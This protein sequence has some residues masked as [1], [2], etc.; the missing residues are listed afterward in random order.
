MKSGIDEH[1]QNG[2]TVPNNAAI[3]FAFSPRNRAS[4]FRWKMTLNVGD[5]KYEYP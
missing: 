5:D 1:E 4:S 3:I 2:V